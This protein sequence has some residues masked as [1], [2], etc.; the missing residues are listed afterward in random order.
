MIG[1]RAASNQPTGKQAGL[2]LI[3]L[4]I[5]LVL[6]IVI[7]GAVAGIM[8]SNTQSFRTTRGMAQIQDSVRVG[9]ELLAR[10]IR[11][12]GNV[13]CGTDIQIVNILNPVQGNNA[14]PWQYDWG[15]GVLGLDEDDALA[16]V[17]NR[18]EGTQALIVMSGEADGTY[19]EDYDTGNNSANF[20]VGTPSGGDHSLR[21]GD[22]LLVCNEDQGTIFQ[23]SNGQG[24]NANKIVVN[25]GNSQSP[26]NCTKGLGP[27][28][29]GNNQNQPC[30]TNGNPGPYDK[31]SVVARLSS[32]AWYIGDNERDAEGGR[33]LYMARLANEAGDAALNEI[34]I[35]SGVVDMQLRY[36]LI[37]TAEFIDAGSVNNRWVDVNA[38]E[39]TLQLASQDQNISTDSSADS[40]R[41]ARSFTS[42]IAIRN[43]SL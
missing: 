20:S 35:A 4:M 28:I 1:F 37:D 33:S 18:I 22:I 36:R 17:D 34:E 11:Q 12:A 24:N 3:E 31:N 38:V 25:T 13:P 43:R 6:G 19:V 41:L 29:P 30:N 23:M 10:D 8:L 40:G 39:V 32:V 26:G 16:G 21:N 42:I 7:I 27:I 9:Y 15:D 14:P 5:A 2:A